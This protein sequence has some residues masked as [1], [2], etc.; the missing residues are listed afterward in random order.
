MILKSFFLLCIFFSP[1]LFAQDEELNKT[2][3]DELGVELKDKKKKDKS[4]NPPPAKDEKKEVNPVQE[5]YANSEEGSST[6][7]L[8]ILV[9]IFLILAIL[10]GAFYYILQF[11][12][13]NRNAR[14]PVKG[15]MKLLSHLPLGQGRELQIVEVSGMLFVLGVSENSINLVK[16]ITDPMVKERIFTAKDAY[17]PPVEDFF[18]QLY[19][20]IK[21]K[22]RGTETQQANRVDDFEEEDEKLEEI[23]QRQKA[24]LEEIKKERGKMQKKEN[25][26]NSKNLDF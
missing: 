25:D 17:E 20:A 11:L 4:E 9:R 18:N 3:R 5:R 6:T 12:N 16:E 13:R 19:G 26:K 8:W 2:L 15:E 24:R 14:Y 1:L 10:V 21:G 7:L 23:Q 22:P